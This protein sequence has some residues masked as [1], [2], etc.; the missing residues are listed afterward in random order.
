MF[1]AAAAALTWNMMHPQKDL[2]FPA[3]VH[4]PK[5]RVGTSKASKSVGVG[6]GEKNHAGKG[7]GGKRKINRRGYRCK[8]CYIEVKYLS[9]HMRK[10][11]KMT[12]E[13]AKEA[14][15]KQRVNAARPHTST[16]KGALVSCPIQGC[17]FKAPR[18]DYH[19]IKVHKIA[20][21]GD[22]Y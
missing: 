12:T 19:I 8:I 22:E 13:D 14:S 17:D 20:R 15:R 1:Q 5:I 2:N 10:V 11:H 3:L 7:E 21:G 6:E 4:R 16:A 18:V 9:K